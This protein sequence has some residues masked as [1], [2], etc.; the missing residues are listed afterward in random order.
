MR[1]KPAVV[2]EAAEFSMSDDDRVWGVKPFCLSASA[3]HL[4]ATS[5]IRIR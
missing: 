3:A 1:P 5:A 2:N 4:C